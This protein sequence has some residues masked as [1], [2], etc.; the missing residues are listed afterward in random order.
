MNQLKMFRKIPFG[1]IFHNLSF[2]SSETYRVFNYSHDSNSIFRAAGI[3]AEILS[4]NTVRVLPKKMAVG[5]LTLEDTHRNDSD[6]WST[7]FPW[8]LEI[9]KIT[10]GQMGRVDP[11]VCASFASVSCSVW[12]RRLSH[13]SLHF[14]LCSISDRLRGALVGRCGST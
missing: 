5:F 7:L 3:N 1:R 12:L 4:T 14:Q 8:R 2:E 9:V 6:V 10:R 13:C 11:Q